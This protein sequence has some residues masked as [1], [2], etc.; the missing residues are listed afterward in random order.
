MIYLLEKNDIF[1]IIL[2]YIQD[3]HNF[4]ILNRYYN[5]LLPK[6]KSIRYL[7]LY[8]CSLYKNTDKYKAIIIIKKNKYNNSI[9]F[10]NRNQ[11]NI[12]KKYLYREGCYNHYCCNGTGVLFTN[13][14]YYIHRL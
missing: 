6:H 10:D 2:L 7:D 11:L 14:N 9:H 13:L 4:Y 3:Y 8:S 12:V 1:K 5:S